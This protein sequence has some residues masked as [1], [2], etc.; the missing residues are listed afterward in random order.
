MEL[1][2]IAGEEVGLDKFCETVG[3]DTETFFFIMIEKN[4]P[5]DER[6]SRREIQLNGGTYQL[7]TRLSDLL[8]E[9]FGGLTES[10]IKLNENEVVTPMQAALESLFN[11]YFPDW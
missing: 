8:Q 6:F 5:L 2:E 11:R 4:P 7:V 9:R 1:L 3:V 10:P